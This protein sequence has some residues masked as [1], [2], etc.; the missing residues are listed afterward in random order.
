M[1]QKT[2]WLAKCSQKGTCRIKSFAVGKF[3]LQKSKGQA[4]FV[5]PLCSL[6]SKAS[7][8][9]AIIATILDF[10]LEESDNAILLSVR[11]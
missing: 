7:S 6:P 10:S 2:L 11:D 9:M 1:L 8:S 5:R 3:S 4:Q